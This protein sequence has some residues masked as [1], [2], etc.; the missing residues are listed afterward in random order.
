MV[1]SPALRDAFFGPFPFDSPAA[2]AFGSAANRD[3]VIDSLVDR[4]LGVA[5]AS[6]PTRDEV[7]P[8]LD[9][10]LTG[11]VAGCDAASCGPDRTRTVTKA[12]CS[13]VLA[14]AAVSVH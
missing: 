8:I 2:L 10:L 7:R 3:R 6:Q 14:S 12:L 13:A 9:E 5:L 11:L 1:E 4:M